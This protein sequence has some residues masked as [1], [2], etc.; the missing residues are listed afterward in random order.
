MIETVN[1]T[2]TAMHIERVREYNRNKSMRVYVF[3]FGCQQNEADAEKLRGMAHCMG[4]SDCDRAEDADL[5]LINTCAIREHAELKA[6]S[7][8]GRFKALKKKKNDLI[9]G[10]CGCMAAEPHR[11][12]LI[13][14]DFHY[15]SFTLEPNMLHRMPELVCT[16]MEK[17]QRHFILGEDRGD[18]VEGMPIH[19][20]HRHRAFVSIMYGCNNFCS[21]CIVPYVRGRE[22][23]RAS[24][25]VI[26]ECRELINDGVREITLLGQNVNSYRSDMDFA[27]L[28]SAIAEI[29]GDFIIRFMTSHPKDTS[30]ALIEAMA[31]HRGK[32]APYFH[33]PLQAGSDRVLKAMNR[34]YTAEKYL[35]TLHRLKA[36]L[37]DIAISTDII[38]GVPGEDD[39]DFEATMRILADEEF[40]MV[41]AFLYSEREGTRAASMEP[42]VARE[43][44]DERIARLL[45]QQDAISYKKNE[46]F[47]GKSCR[48]LVDSIETRDGKVVYTG[49]NAENKLV[50][51]TSDYAEIGEFINVKIEKTGAFDLI[52][53]AEK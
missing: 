6:L 53:C 35:D 24:A 1:S 11:A 18:I 2:S 42:K 36:A 50:H 51:F 31:E 21:Y 9:I 20:T 34:T 33:L 38:V 4:Y 22:R 41:Y 30:D 26:R 10:V 28:I 43:V 15:V 52:G 14:E 7:M 44:K 48:V 45:E 13:K 29:E 27:S 32:I 23:S 39:E 8:L 47:L 12:A 40:D 5:I 16:Y 46:R 37:P 49:R 17:R 19:R 25:D 3:T